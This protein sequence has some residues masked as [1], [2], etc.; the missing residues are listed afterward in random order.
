M[1][2]SIIRLPFL[3]ALDASGEVKSKGGVLAQAVSGYLVG[4]LLRLTQPS[5]KRECIEHE[6]GGLGILSLVKLSIT[7]SSQSKTPYIYSLM[8]LPDSSHSANTI[9][10]ELIQ[11]K[12]ETGLAHGSFLQK[13]AAFKPRSFSAQPANSPM[14]FIGRSTLTPN[15]TV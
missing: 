1:P 14:K 6:E 5:E 7:T 12:T 4:W 11:E 9:L 8:F 10:W 15:L 3:D 2:L 13:S